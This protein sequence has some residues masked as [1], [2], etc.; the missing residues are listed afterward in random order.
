[1]GHPPFGHN[2][3]YAL[4]ALMYKSGGFEGNA[5]TL[6]I[7]SRLEKKELEPGLPHTG[8]LKNGSDKRL[9]LNLTFRSLASVLKYDKEIPRTV[10]RPRDKPKKGYY[11]SEAEIV[12]D[13][14]DH[15]APGYRGRHFQTIECSI[16][17]KADDIAYSTYDLEDAFKAGFTSPLEMLSSSPQVLKRIQS[18]LKN[19]LSLRRIQEVIFDFFQWTIMPKPDGDGQENKVSTM[20]PFLANATAANNSSKLFSQD[21]QLRNGHASDLVGFLINNIQLVPNTKYPCLSSICFPTHINDVVEVLKQYAYVTII[22]SPM[23]KVV[24]YRGFDIVQKLFKAIEKSTKNIERSLLPD[25][26][27]ELYISAKPA[28]RHRIIC[29]FIAGMTDRYALEFYGRLYS[30]RPQSIFKPL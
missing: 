27:R 15:V 8:F 21:A 19:S 3:E 20:P 26:F 24:E 6:R 14:K 11:H 30:E 5:Q 29:D 7:L 17:E 2:G 23:L 1:M 16:M 25:D 28:E 10:V 9:G 22:E 12:E 4:D 13:I 18:H